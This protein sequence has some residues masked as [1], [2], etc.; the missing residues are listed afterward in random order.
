M[1][2]ALSLLDHFAN[3]PDPR[4]ERTQLHSLESILLIAICGVIC[5]AE[6]WAAIERFGQAKLD[7]FNKIIELPNG[8]PSHDTFGRVFA[9]LNTESFNDA[10][11]AWVPC[12]AKALGTDIVAIDGKTMRRTRSASKGEPAIHLVSAFAR[13]HGVA[14]GQV[15]VD[16]KSNEIT[17]I[18][19]LLQKLA[20]SGCLVT[21]DAMGCQKA[22]AAHIVDAGADYVLSL[23][24][25]HGTAFDEVQSYFAHADATDFVN[26]PH[27]RH[28]DVDAGHGR[29]E[30]RRVDTAPMD[31]FPD[32][33]LWKGLQSVIRV[34][35][36]RHMGATTSQETRYFLSTLPV[37][38]VQRAAAGVRGHWAI[39]NQLHWCLDVAFNEDQQRMRTGDAAANMALLN[40][41]ALNLLT[42]ETSRKVGI[43]IRRLEAG[44]NEAYL[45]K[46]LAAGVG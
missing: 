30:H 10:F 28:E 16:S 26:I 9:A 17:A 2:P 29:V 1:S 32:Q 6:N 41:L 35:S 36:Q 13:T 3:V 19:A 12:L 25:N 40:K 39:E 15:A 4:L 8:I 44:W 33:A 5:G 20:L 42:R 37:A 14:L 7:F 43:K 34:Q 18:P 46:V 11:M 45:L 27:G 22:I 24:G 21:L 31:W 23:K 38:E